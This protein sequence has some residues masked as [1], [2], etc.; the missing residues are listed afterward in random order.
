MKFGNFL[1]PFFLLFSIILVVLWMLGRCRYKIFRQQR[2]QINNELIVTL[3]S[4]MKFKLCNFIIYCC[5]SSNDISADI[6]KF[7]DKIYVISYQTVKEATSMDECVIC[8]E[9]FDAIKQICFFKC[10]H[11]FHVSCIVKWL[12][13]QK[14]CPLCWSDVKRHTSHPPLTSSLH[15]KEYGIATIV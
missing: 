13:E 6:I 11:C 1:I 10:K 14:K 3:H 9:Q 2:K 7:Y 8:K 15:G 5:W 4:G 12:A